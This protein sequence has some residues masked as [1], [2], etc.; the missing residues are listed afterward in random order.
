MDLGTCMKADRNC[1]I[2][3]FVVYFFIFFYF[4]FFVLGVGV[5]SEERRRGTCLLYIG[6]CGLF[7]CF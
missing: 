1:Y 5:G 6:L 7:W 2:C 3:G 4:Y